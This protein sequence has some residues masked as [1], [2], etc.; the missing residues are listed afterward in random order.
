MM[1]IASLT[2]I[3]AAE[4]IYMTPKT[5]HRYCSK[6]VGL[7]TLLKNPFILTKGLKIYLVKGFLSKK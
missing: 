5:A 2:L 6:W 4:G 7:K 1:I 3:S